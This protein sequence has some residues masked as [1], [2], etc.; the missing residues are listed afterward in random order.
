MSKNCIQNIDIR[1]K[2]RNLYF[3]EKCE[4]EIVLNYIALKFS[5]LQMNMGLPKQN[6]IKVKK[7]RHVN[8]WFLIII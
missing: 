4:G 8:I 2:E 1:I 3:A 5:I 6:G 7:L